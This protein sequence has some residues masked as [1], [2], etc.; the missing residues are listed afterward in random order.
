M[1]KLEVM[2]QVLVEAQGYGLICFVNQGKFGKTYE[3]LYHYSVPP[4]QL[5]MFHIFDSI[6][7]RV[8]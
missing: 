6:T 4:S 8:R 3:L 1:P 5:T 2:G 7:K